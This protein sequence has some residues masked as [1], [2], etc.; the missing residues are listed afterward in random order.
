MSPDRSSTVPSLLVNLV[1]LARCVVCSGPACDAV[2]WS[3][4]GRLQPVH[5]T[6]LTRNS[7]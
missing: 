5:E 4:D 1:A 3:L 7:S 6:C 2:L